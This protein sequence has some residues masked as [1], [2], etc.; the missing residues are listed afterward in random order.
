MS[1]ASH[2]AAFAAG[3]VI[4]SA[5]AASAV[6]RADVTRFK[7]IDAFAQAL[8]TVEANYVD[9]TD[10]RKLL[11]DATR[12]M[13]HNLDRHST[14]L[15]PSRYQ[16]LRQ[17]TEGEFGGVGVTLAPGELDDARPSMPPYPTIE[18]LVRGSPADVAG[19]QID[20]SV[21]AIDGEAT[22]EAGH[23]KRDAGTWENRLR[24][25]SGT[26][27]TVSIVR[28]GWRDPRPFVLVR[29][30]V[31]QPTVRHDIPEKGIGYLA[32]TRFSEST[33]ADVIA[34]LAKLRQ[35]G[36][37]GALVLDLRNNPGGLVDQAIAVADLFLDAGTIVTIRGRKGSVETQVA[38][39]GGA[40]VGVPV[41]ALV[42]QGTASAAEILAAALHDQGRAEL[43]GVPTYGKGTVQTFYD[44]EDGS[45][46]KLTTAR[47]YTPSGNS[48]ESKGIIP[49]VTVEPFTPEEIVSG[50]GNGSG[51]SPRN[52]A[53][54]RALADD[55]Q[56][57]AA[58]HRAR[59]ARPQ[60]RQGASK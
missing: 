17:D 9:L 35:Q 25:A 48:L 26:R 32:I 20:D 6:P 15:P 33:H 5:V 31:K 34:S 10:E 56:L 14:F 4:A 50:S 22:A 3:A 23:E 53:T 13:L 49:E 11:Y 39:K 30:Q 54:I 19:L 45:G 24:G 21:V 37:L 16:H 55:P 29:A 52:G 36:A 12:G 27:V 51:A 1:R 38:H 47:Y 57:A 18:G 60:A 59:Q 40:A 44:L 7:A 43:V 42:D 58:L 8:A 46:L 2:A 41:V 28:T